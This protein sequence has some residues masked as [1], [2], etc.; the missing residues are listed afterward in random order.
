MPLS[1]TC[2]AGMEP[3]FLPQMDGSDTI[4]KDVW[5]RTKEVSSDAGAVPDIEREIW[6]KDSSE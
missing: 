2:V 6:G 3:Q 5:T 1:S 4:Y